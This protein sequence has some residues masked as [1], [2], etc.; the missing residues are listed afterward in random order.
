M[1]NNFA[2]EG[3]SESIDLAFDRHQDENYATVNDLDIG[4]KKNEP[5]LE[6]SAEPSNEDDGAQVA[7]Q[8]A[9]EIQLQQQ[10]NDQRLN[11][12]KLKATGGPIRTKIPSAQP[13]RIVSTT[14]RA[15]QNRNAQ[16][17]FRQRKE[18]YIKDLEATAAQVEIL[19]QT[20]E[21]L[22]TENLQLRD[23]TLNLQSKVLELSGSHET[24]LTGGPTPPVFNKNFEK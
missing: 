14:K 1:N 11:E 22:K 3:N 20:V 23:Y 16:K 24:D 15:A 18:K 13:L 8:L 6:S 5:K 12:E 10:Q 9:A 21:D 7:A 2:Y 19:K 17:A 4:G